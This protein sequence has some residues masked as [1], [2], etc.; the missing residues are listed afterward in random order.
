M[1]QTLW[2]VKNDVKMGWFTNDIS[3]WDYYTRLNYTILDYTR[4][5]YTILDYTR[6]YYTRLYYTKIDQEWDG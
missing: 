6:L 1:R 2:A 5:D 3:E 4:L